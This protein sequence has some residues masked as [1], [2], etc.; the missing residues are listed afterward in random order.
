MK[1]RFKKYL[2][3][4]DLLYSSGGITFKEM[5]EKW[6]ESSLNDRKTI[7]AKRTFDD[8]RRA[9]EETFDVDVICDASRGYQYRI[10]DAKS[11]SS[12]RIK[13]WLLSS[14]AVNNILQGCKKLSDRI[15]YEDIPSGND[16]LLEVVKAM[17]KNHKILVEYDNFFEKN[18]KTLEIEPYCVKVFRQ[19]WYVIG[20]AKGEKDIWRWALDRFLSIE[21]IDKKFRL[22]KD[23]FAD[24]Y[25]RDA[26]GVIVDE[27]ECP[28]ETIRFKAFSANHRDEYLRHL[29]LHSS[30][31]EIE[32]HGDYSI[33]EVRVRPAYDFC[34]ELLSYGEEIEVLSPQ[35]VRDYIAERIKKAVERY[36]VTS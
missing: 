5:A 26:Y 18:V 20:K 13:Q 16:D 3:I 21:V 22:P 11:L 34:Q 36:K 7:L 2:W 32:Q 30:Q 15:I 9:I 10:D 27:K 35:Y 29:P 23:F 25:F 31:R 14:F 1:D 19:R 33:F 17:Q 8:Y 6:K 4:L 28:V 24:I 12:D